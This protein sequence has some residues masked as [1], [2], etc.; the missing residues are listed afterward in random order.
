[1]RR[2]GDDLVPKRIVYGVCERNSPELLFDPELQAAPESITLLCKS[3]A[4]PAVSART[5]STEDRT[6]GTNTTQE[7]VTNWLNSIA[8]DWLPILQLFWCVGYLEQESLM[9][10]GIAMGYRR[11]EE[12]LGKLENKKQ[13]IG[14]SFIRSDSP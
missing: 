3:V 11:L 9:Q 5:E 4:A 10:C 1:M 6:V 2:I 13:A 12:L 7:K 14:K 8:V